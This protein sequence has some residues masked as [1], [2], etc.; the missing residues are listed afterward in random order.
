MT[1]HEWAKEVETL[2][3]ANAH[4]TKECQ[5]Y[6]DLYFSGRKKRETKVQQV[7]LA[8]APPRVE[9]YTPFGVANL[10]GQLAE[11]LGQ[12]VVLTRRIVARDGELQRL[13]QALAIY[14]V[15]GRDEEDDDLF[16][17]TE[18]E[19]F[20]IS[21]RGKGTTLKAIGAMEGVGAERIRQIEAKAR[22]KMARPSRAKPA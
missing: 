11:A 19:R 22:R 18:R 12:I 13:R 14:R 6:S 8:P 20:V 1:E 3:S 5:R 16:Y 7:Y 17:L 15:Q 10:K 2:R 9:V 21:E 4:L